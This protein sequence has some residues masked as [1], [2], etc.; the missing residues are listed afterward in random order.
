MK[1]LIDYNQLDQLGFNVNERTFTWREQLSAVGQSLSKIIDMDN[2][3]GETATAV[4]NYLGEIY[5][6][7]LLAFDET[8]NELSLRY[9]MYKDGYLNNIDPDKQSMFCEETFDENLRFF[10]NSEGDFESLHLRLQNLFNNISHIVPNANLPQS[11]SVSNS[12]Q[13]T[14]RRIYQ[15]RQN[16][17]NHE[18]RHFSQDFV[19][20]DRMLDSLNGFISTQLNNTGCI[21]S[22]VSGVSFSNEYIL[23]LGDT[24]QTVFA[25]RQDMS[26]EIEAAILREQERFEA[27]LAQ[28]RVQDGW[29]QRVTGIFQIVGGVLV[30]VVSIG[31]LIATKGASWHLATAGI[32]GGLGMIT[33]GAASF[34]EGSN[35]IA[36]GRAGDVTTPAN[37]WLRDD[38]LT[39]LPGVNED[40]K[41]T[42]HFVFATASNTLGIL[43]SAG[44]SGWA[45]AANAGV[46]S[47]QGIRQAILFS[48][49]RTVL[50]VGAGF[51][52]NW[53]GN[54]AGT[55]IWDENVG[56]YVGLG[57]G[58]LAGFG[59]R[60]GITRVSNTLN[61][62]G[63]RILQ[64]NNGLGAVYL[65]NG[66][67]RLFGI[68]N[69][70]TNSGFVMT[71]SPILPSNFNKMF[72]IGNYSV[73]SFA[74][75]KPAL[76]NASTFLR[77]PS[78]LPNPHPSTIVPPVLLQSPHNPAIA[79]PAI[80]PPS[81]LPSLYSP[82]I[83]PPVIR[84]PFSLPS[85]HPSTLVPPVLRPPALLPS[86]HPS[87]IAPS[88]I[89]IPPSLLNPHP[90]TIVP[91]TPNPREINPGKWLYTNYGG[92]DVSWG[93][94]R[95]ADINRRIDKLTNEIRRAQE[96]GII[97]D[98]GD[99]LELKV[100]EVVR[101]MGLLTGFGVNIIRGTGKPKRGNAGDIDVLTDDFIIEIKASLNAFNNDINKVDKFADPMNKDYFNH[102]DRMIIFFIDNIVVEPSVQHIW[103]RLKFW[104]GEGRIMIV[105]CVDELKNILRDSIILD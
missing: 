60:Q 41:H 45:S 62:D 20:F 16:V 26:S 36:L 105:D 104:E 1:F 50:S 24:L 31:S 46:T 86:S 37:N 100:M 74:P 12:Y 67:F 89:R 66:N 22:H 15:L 39:L 58:L 23:A 99:V 52:G 57:A 7:I 32:V 27:L 43:G 10:S 13:E 59:M 29:W 47:S 68:G 88:V 81:V 38:V 54:R 11:S 70:Q 30:I 61:A 4:K 83:V 92:F 73:S 102:D 5:G 55:A 78:V 82:S 80:R 87:T 49:F 84:P 103:D 93:E 77:P 25:E 8:F 98:S 90:S 34:S 72:T 63:V 51:G 19:N 40:N 65:K 53:I 3:T 64:S 85:L 14:G 17:D 91:A 6:I 75:L 21:S 42:A 9:L 101:D 48:E 33:N 71:N 69:A 18:R 76:P 28:Q 56:R 44:A 95:L 97:P 35:N 2:F 96:N 94:P 79:P